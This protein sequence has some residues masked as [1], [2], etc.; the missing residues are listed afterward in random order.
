MRMAVH[1][2]VVA[3]ESR[4]GGVAESEQDERADS[5][6]GEGSV[7]ILTTISSAT[8]GARCFTSVQEV[9]WQSGKS[10]LAFGFHLLPFEN[11]HAARKC[12]FRDS[13][14]FYRPQAARI[15]YQ[16]GFAS[17]RT[18]RVLAYPLC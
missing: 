1:V 11:C 10:R 13:T 15:M 2:P 9:E 18:V 16:R 17:N 5:G 14:S 12:L 3:E 4:G 7:L 8:N 6:Q